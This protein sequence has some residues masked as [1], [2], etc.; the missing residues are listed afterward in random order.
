[1]SVLRR[2]SSPSALAHSPHA[3]YSVHCLGSEAQSSPPFDFCPV[4][5]REGAR[6]TTIG[7]R[8]KPGRIGAPSV[9]FL[10]KYLQA[11][12]APQS[13]PHRDCWRRPSGDG[14]RERDDE[15]FSPSHTRHSTHAAAEISGPLLRP[16]QPRTG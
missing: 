2:S 11:A 13:D 14:A 7:A 6:E 16:S 1:M 12:G 15:A 8:E 3:S 5:K 9:P 4:T 10:M